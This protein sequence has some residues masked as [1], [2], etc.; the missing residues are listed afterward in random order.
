MPAVLAAALALAAASGC[1]KTQRTVETAD[2]TLE[3]VF[4]GETKVL[5]E[6]DPGD[7]PRSPD[8]PGLLILALDGVG[9]D[10]LYSALRAR[11]MPELS[12]LLGD[13]AHFEDD[14]LSVLPSDTLPAW[15]SAFTGAPPGVHG[16]AGNEFFVREEGELE[17]PAPTSF[18]DMAAVLETY[19]DDEVDDQLAAPTVYEQI[20]ARDPHVL[21]WVMMSQI[22]RG[23]DEL[24]LTDR[25]ILVSAMRA[26]V[27]DLV[28]D[29]ERF[30]VFAA[31]DREVV[32]ELVEEIEEEEHLPDV[33]TVYIAGTDGYA[34]VAA[35]GPD[36][37]RQRY[38]VEVVDPLVGD[39]RRALEARGEL[40]D[41]Y[42]IVTSDHGHTAV[43]DDDE[44][45]LYHGDDDPP[46]VLE[47]AGYRVRPLRLKADGVFD[48]VLA[49]QGAFA[50]VY[51]ADRSTC[52]GD[53]T[54]CDFSQPPRRRE[55]V[56]PAA[57]AFAAA[58]R[59]GA[60]VPA[61]KGTLDLVLVRT[62]GGPEPLAVVDSGG[63]LV[64][65]STF[66]EHHPQ[67]E[68]VAL[69]PRLEALASGPM[70]HRAGDV[71]LLAHL[72]DRDDPGERYYFSFPYRSWHGSPSPQDSRIPLVVAHP[73]RSRA[74]LRA[75]VERALGDQPTIDRLT[76]LL[77]ELRFGR[78]P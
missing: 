57:R 53:D 43:R 8:R 38:L 70:S 62:P 60:H 78:A 28:D 34:H 65:L 45:A 27:V 71:I 6:R 74:E 26:M 32:E 22:F 73:Q 50:Y 10:Q 44:H 3:L 76:P 61:M 41:R 77:L 52:P 49:Y 48:A 56:L 24:L 18:H 72:G 47:A 69:R 21:V 15:A 68:Y 19:T 37:A 14:F 67:R 7:P 75:V 51:L 42:V 29:E 59:R 30:A 2:E 55:D 35:V 11:M 36:A 46:A 58:S 23:A 9:R 13:R 54:P 33:L 20:R 1:Y 40:D 63:E 31:L 39:L 16:I 5:R 25:K 4:T 12:A 17:A 64:P 66:L